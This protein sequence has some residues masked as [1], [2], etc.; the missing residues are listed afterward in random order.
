MS[1][2]ANCEPE[3]RTIHL[4]NLISEQAI[5]ANPADIYFPHC[6]RTAQ[7]GGCCPSKRL[8]CEPT[9]VEE[10]VIPVCQL[11]LIHFQFICANKI[12]LL[13]CSCSLF[14]F[15]TSIWIFRHCAGVGD[16]TFGLLVSVHW[17]GKWMSKR[18]A[19]PP[20]RVSL[21]LSCLGSQSMPRATTQHFW[22]QVSRMEWTRLSL[23]MSITKSI[24]PLSCGLSVQHTKVQVILYFSQQCSR[25][26]VVIIIQLSFSIAAIVS[27][28]GPKAAGE[29]RFVML[30]IWLHF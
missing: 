17:E 5:Q 12:A 2:T 16:E 4:L 18:R 6:I 21:R 13:D 1:Q 11:I 14:G 29:L 22:W 24:S 10:D 28:L 25:Q 26:R 3:M 19:L 23:R 9:E 15:A 27:L 7:C 20:W 30:K 8:A